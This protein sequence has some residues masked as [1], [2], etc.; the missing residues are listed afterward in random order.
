M[1]CEDYGIKINI[2]KTKAMVIGRKSKKIDIQ[3]TDESVELVD[4]FKYL[5]CIPG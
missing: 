1:T 2:N 4:S 3:I 5:G